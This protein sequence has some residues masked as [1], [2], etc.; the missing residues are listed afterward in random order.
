MV[1]Y[2]QKVQQNSMKYGNFSFSFQK[3]QK[4]LLVVLLCFR[5]SVLEVWQE[6]R[7]FVTSY[8]ILESYVRRFREQG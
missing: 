8:L 2:K 5:D 4:I 1:P 7:Q 6:D 3:V